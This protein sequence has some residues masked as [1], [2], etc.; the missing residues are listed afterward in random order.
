[1]PA[2]MNARRLTILSILLSAAMLVAGCGVFKKPAPPAPAGPAMIAVEPLASQQARAYPEIVPGGRVL[3]LADFEDEPSPAPGGPAAGRAPGD[4]ESGGLAAGRADLGGADASGPAAARP[5]IAGRRQVD[6]FS[7]V[8]ETA[9]AARQ[10]VVNITRTGVGAM[11]VT[12]PAGLGPHGGAQLVL[13]IPAGLDVRPYKLLSMALFSRALR[14]DLQV[15]I[16]SDGGSWQS[17]RVLVEPGWNTVLLDIRQLGRTGPFDA[18]SVRRL[19]LSFA[20]AAEAVWFN[21]DDVMLM[22]NSRRIKPVPA[23][24]ELSKSGLDYELKLPGRQE[25]VLI[26]QGSDGLWRLGALGAEIRLGGLGEKLPAGGERL[27]A[28]GSRRVGRIELLEHNEIR[29]RLASTWYFPSRAGQWASMAVRQIR[30]EYT[31]YGDGRCVVQGVLNNAGG[32]EIATVGLFTATDA[33]FYGGTTGRQMVVNDFAGEVGRWRYMVLPQG[34]FGAVLAANYLHP[35]AIRPSVAEPGVR[36][37]GD[38]DRDGFDESQGCYFLAARAGQCRFTLDPPPEGLLDPVVLLAGPWQGQVHV[39][40]E[41]LAIRSVVRRPD[42]SALVLLGGLHRKAMAVEVSGT[43]GAAPE[44]VP[45]QD[46]TGGH[47]ATR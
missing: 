11:E 13:E 15:T 16:D 10:F 20:D 18:S 4:D 27:D 25:A 30:R 2:S 17:L 44:H 23:G 33:A 42:G 22:D 32:R 31:I 36:A 3:C 45:S 19:R 7:I 41:G 12:L 37:D 29:I 47:V 1:M 46:R 24:A 6:R 9:G 34:P 8:P 28:L 38:G 26:E 40:S 14:D 5:P 39:S 43:A 21:L 35:G